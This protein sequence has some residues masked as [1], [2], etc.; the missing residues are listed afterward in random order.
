MVHDWSRA[1]YP[2]NAALA[3]PPAQ[4][5]A[6]DDFLQVLPPGAYMGGA[7]LQDCFLHWFVAPADRRFLGVRRPLTGGLGVYLFVPFGLGPSPGLNDRCV[8]AILSVARAR[9]PSLRIVDFADDALLVDESGG[10]DELDRR[11][12]RLMS[13]LGE[14]GVRYHTKAGKR[15]WP[16]R[17][18]RGWGSR[19]ALRA[20]S[21]VWR[22][23]RWKRVFALARRFLSLDRVRPCRLAPYWQ[24]CRT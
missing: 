6:M 18:I 17:S 8:K 15:W 4:F 7:G 3:N 1:S 9:F 14:M 16:A 11:M 23:G 24:R 21:C 10:H 13:L 20:T 2:M 12:A 5:G 19:W 22:N